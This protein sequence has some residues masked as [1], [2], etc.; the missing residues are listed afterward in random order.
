MLYQVE[1]FVCLAELLLP[2]RTRMLRSKATPAAKLSRL[3]R[4]A[5]KLLLFV[6]HIKNMNEKMLDVSYE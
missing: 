5:K 3:C 6:S 2:L 4:A 1:L